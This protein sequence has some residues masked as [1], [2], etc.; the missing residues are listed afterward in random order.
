MSLRGAIAEGLCAGA[1]IG[2]ILT[3]GKLDLHSAIVTEAIVKERDAEVATEPLLM[4]PICPDQWIAMRGAG[5][6]WNVRCAL[7]S[8]EGSRVVE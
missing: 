7:S 2:A 1:A 8:T 5:G 4:R 3:V 6:R